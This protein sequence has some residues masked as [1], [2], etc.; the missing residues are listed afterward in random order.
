MNKFLGSFKK[1]KMQVLTKLTH[2]F[3]AFP[4]KILMGLFII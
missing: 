3:K 2:K 4:N 1:I